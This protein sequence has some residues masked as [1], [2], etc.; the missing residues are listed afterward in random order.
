MTVPPPDGSRDRRI[1]DPS[2]LWL[3]HP[4]GR[5][6]L[7]VAVA[8]GV[9]ANAVSIAGLALGTAAALAY[10]RLGDWRF[11]LIGL[12][13]SIGWLV[14]DG[15][16]GMVARATGTASP[17]GRMLD[18]LCDHGVFLLI[19]VALAIVWGT[20][21][22]WALAFAAGG[23]HAVQSSLFEGE[24]TRF[25]RRVKGVALVAAPPAPAAS[26]LVRLYDRVAGMPDRLA[27]AFE[28]KLA[29]SPDPVATG[30]RYARAAV[31]PMRLLSL[32]TANVRIFMVFVACLAGDPRLFWWFEIVPLT[33]ILLI[34][35]AWHRRVERAL[36]SSVIS[37]A[38][39]EAPAR[40]LVKEQGQ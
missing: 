6:L 27:M 5:L 13:L 21:A 35:L 31:A 20:P 12:V 14:A 30:A 11:A 23:V 29:A 9:S 2:N 22:G 26:S 3:I 24:R 15:L 39:A 25:H 16:D 19:Y 34:G 38:P 32:E 7:P 1:E 17:L 10:A 8:R 33:A 18:G 4:L 37:S 40:Y 36:L 28:Q